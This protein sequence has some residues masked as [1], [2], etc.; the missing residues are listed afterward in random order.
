MSAI[1]EVLRDARESISDPAR[2][3]QC[4]DAR[5]ETGKAV[6]FDDPDAVRWCLMGAVW[7]SA[8][9]LNKPYRVWDASYQSLKDAARRLKMFYILPTTINDVVGHAAVLNLLDEAI[10]WR[11][12]QEAASA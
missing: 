6:R 9:K 1:L 10:A 5:T 2:W 12:S 11:V 7:R 4:V 8:Q 3:T